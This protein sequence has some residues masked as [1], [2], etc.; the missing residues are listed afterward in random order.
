VLSM[1]SGQRG[2]YIWLVL[3][4][5][6][7]GFVVLAGLF[8][9]AT[10]SAE[11]ALAIGVVYLGLVA[12]AMGKNLTRTIQ[13]PKPALRMPIR[14]T[15]A[16]RKATQ[17]A[18][19]R[20]GYSAD[21]TLTDVG[22]IINE[23]RPDGKWNRHL[24][25]VVSMDDDAV[26][27]YITIHVPPETSNRLAL[28]K[29]ELYDQAGRLQFSRQVEQWVR[30]GDNTIICD[31]QLP[32]RTSDSPGRSGVWDLRVTMDGSPYAIHSFTM[33]PST[34]DRRQQFDNEGEVVTDRLILTD[35]EPMSL[36]D[37]LREQRSRNSQ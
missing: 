2:I 25:Q 9:A 27:P 10:I 37:L 1:R 12:F 17:R 8:G 28:V 18:R 36:E 30:D 35:D 24:A 16:A 7:V 29:F 32:L 11:L 15:P 3:L 19:T 5:L 20:P 6:V 33:T 23:R 21:S 14:A 31:R 13:L 22:M 4:G 34:G 26:Q